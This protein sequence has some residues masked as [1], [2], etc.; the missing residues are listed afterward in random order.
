MSSKARVEKVQVDVVD[1]EVDHHVA[2][3]RPGNPWRR[4]RP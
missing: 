3:R 1:V 4:A 2:L